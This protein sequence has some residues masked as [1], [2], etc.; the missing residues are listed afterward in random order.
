MVDNYGASLLEVNNNYKYRNVKKAITR[1]EKEKMDLEELEAMM[2]NER[3]G[4][5]Y[6]EQMPKKKFR[7]NIQDHIEREDFP[8]LSNVEFWLLYTASVNTYLALI[9][10]NLNKKAKI[11]AK[12]R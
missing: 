7:L 12:K 3:A 8:E 1:E 2:R 11:T 4:M 9:D 10:N 5:Q 6:G